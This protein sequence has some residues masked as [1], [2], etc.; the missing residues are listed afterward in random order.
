VKRLR[1]LH[2]RHKQK[3]EVA[4]YFKR[5]EEAEKIYLYVGHEFTYYCQMACSLQLVRSDMDRKDLAIDLRMRLGDWHRV[6]Q[7]FQ[8]IGGGDDAM[9]NLARQRMGDYYADRQRWKRAIAY[10]EAAKHYEVRIFDNS[11]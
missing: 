3:A 10:Y 9:L 4:V 8:Q 2:D 6:L 5:F 1:I 11:F 7:L